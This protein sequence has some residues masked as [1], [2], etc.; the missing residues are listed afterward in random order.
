MCYTYIVLFWVFKVLNKS[1]HVK[2]RLPYTKLRIVFSNILAIKS[3]LY[4]D[5][6]CE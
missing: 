6:R 4:S 2:W 5:G 1:L 3:C